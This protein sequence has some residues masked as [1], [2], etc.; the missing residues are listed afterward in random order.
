MAVQTMRRT[1]RVTSPADFEEFYRW[2]RPG[3]Y[4]AL[5]LTLGDADLAAE[6]VDEALVRAYQRWGRVRH[7]DNAAGWAY[8]VG[9]NWALSRTRKRKRAL[10]VASVP[11]AGAAPPPTAPD[12][13][14][15][16]ALA[17][18]PEQQ[19]AVVV[20]RYHLD[21][22]TEQ[23]AAALGVAPGTVKSRLHRALVALRDALEETR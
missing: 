12:D 21:W 1:G 6:A 4:R 16:T 17:G 9:L 2:E 18:L 7:Y 11:E 15:E 3:V 8:R 10:P 19:R 13:E 5:A 14:L 20:L 22:S 23:A